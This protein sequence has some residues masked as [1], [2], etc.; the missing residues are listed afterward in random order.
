MF[1]PSAQL[2]PTHRAS[3]AWAPKMDTWRSNKSRIGALDAALSHRTMRGAAC[4]NGPKVI[5]W[6]RRSR[7]CGLRARPRLE[8]CLPGQEDGFERIAE[9]KAISGPR[10]FGTMGPYDSRTT[11]ELIGLDAKCVEGQSFRTTHVS[12]RVFVE[13]L[14][15]D[16]FLVKVSHFFRG[17]R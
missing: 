16:P 5:L 4:V 1:W 8:T 10:R 2:T 13:Y 17:A 15:A 3:V 7:L 12:E 14:R 9:G 11:G 6:G